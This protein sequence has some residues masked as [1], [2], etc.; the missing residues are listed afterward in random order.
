MNRS[1]WPPARAS[2]RRSDGG[3]RGTFETLR[4]CPDACPATVQSLG[5]L[6]AQMFDSSPA[7]SSNAGTF[8]K[9]PDQVNNNVNVVI[10]ARQGFSS[11]R[12]QT[13]NLNL[14]E[15]EC[16]NQPSTAMLI[17]DFTH[18]SLP[19]GTP[20]L[21]ASRYRRNISVETWATTGNP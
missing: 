5:G 16:L 20:A 15:T 7:P 19:R 1:Y 12:G 9:C 11:I 2:R 6:G 10:L 4:A 14:G 18:I 21:G 13:L 17:I 8:A 3:C